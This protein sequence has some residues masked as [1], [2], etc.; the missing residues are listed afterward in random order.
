MWRGRSDD[1]GDERRDQQSIHTYIVFILSAQSR[2]TP[3]IEPKNSGGLSLSLDLGNST[4]AQSSEAFY[5]VP[6]FEG[7]SRGHAPFRRL[8]GTLEGFGNCSRRSLVSF[9]GATVCTLLQS[10]A[11]S[12]NLVAKGI[13]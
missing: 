7:D 5:H 13:L 11:I 1:E 9:G 6:C 12:V 2:F 3:N 10:T 8:L 4:K